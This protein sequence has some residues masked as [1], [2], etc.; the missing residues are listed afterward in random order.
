MQ[1]GG[2]LEGNPLRRCKACAGA[3]RVTCSK[4]RGAGMANSWLWRTSLEVPKPVVSDIDAGGKT[5]DFP[6]FK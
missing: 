3:G 6:L 5:D 4:C 2:I 1:S